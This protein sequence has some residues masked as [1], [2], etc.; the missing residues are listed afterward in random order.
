MRPGL[1]K[2]L[3]CPVW[4]QTCGPPASASWVDW[5][6]VCNTVPTSGKLHSLGSMVGQRALNGHLRGGHR[7]GS[8]RG[9][10][11]NQG[12]GGTRWGHSDQARRMRGS[13]VTAA[14]P[15]TTAVS[16]HCAQEPGVRSSE[17]DA[18]GQASQWER[19]QRISLHS[20]SYERRA[21]ARTAGQD[22]VSSVAG[23]GRQRADHAG[24]PA[25]GPVARTLRR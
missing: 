2:L 24:R 1:T 17:K 7:S 8:R 12:P 22:S 3:N 23:L 6:A 5:T 13:R 19:S 14:A 10:C 20:V 4:T 21:G 15:R 18:S 9:E 11:T 16:S 25:H